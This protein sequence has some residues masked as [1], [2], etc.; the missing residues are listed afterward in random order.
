MRRLVARLCPSL[1]DLMDCS[2]PGLS[3]ASLGKNTG[4]GSHSLL[5]GSGDGGGNRPY[6]GIEPRSPALQGVFFAIWATREV[7]SHYPS[8]ITIIKIHQRWK[9]R[10]KV[11]QQQHEGRICVFVTVYP[12]SLRVCAHAHECICAHLSSFISLCVSAYWP[13]IWHL[14]LQYSFNQ[15]L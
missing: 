1:Y 3:T 4:V 15:S 13:C 10:D 12:W 9:E 14:T 5:G 11:M 6:L 8:I 2:P 7:Q